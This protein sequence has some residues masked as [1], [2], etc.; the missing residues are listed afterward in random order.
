MIQKVIVNTTLFPSVSQL[1]KYSI[2]LFTINDHLKASIYQSI[3]IRFNFIVN[4]HFLILPHI[5]E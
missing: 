4:D 5:I 2:T 3:L 1:I